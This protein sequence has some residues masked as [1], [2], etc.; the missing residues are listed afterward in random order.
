MLNVCDCVWLFR[1]G[2][3]MNSLI[4]LQQIYWLNFIM[5]YG[6]QMSVFFTFFQD[7]IHREDKYFLVLTP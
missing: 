7:N 2:K 4:V 6:L 1:A 3:C 5:D